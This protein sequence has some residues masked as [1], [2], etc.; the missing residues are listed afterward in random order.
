MIWQKDRQELQLYEKDKRITVPVQYDTMDRKKA[1]SYSR[2]FALWERTGRGKNEGIPK[3][4]DFLELFDCLRIEELHCEVRW[5]E[6][7]P[8]KRLKA[9]IGK[10]MQGA[11]VYLDVHEKFHGPHGLIAGTTGSGKSE[12]LQTYLLSLMIQFS[13]QDVNFFVI[14]YKGGG[15]ANLFKNLPHLLGT[16]TNLDGAE[17]HRAMVSIKSELARRQRVFNEYGVNHING[18]HKLYQL[19]KAREPIP[20][21]FLISD[22]FAELKKEQPEFMKE[23]VSTA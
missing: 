7:R 12:L 17:S 4:V 21:L 1:S 5:Q 2:N 11:P 15:M 10:G 6:A 18:Y 13:P 23:L 20:H 3:N 14:D 16:I 22:E 9:V 19:G 8:E